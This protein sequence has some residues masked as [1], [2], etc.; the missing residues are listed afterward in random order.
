MKKRKW[1]IC[2]ICIFILVITIG[3]VAVGQNREKT[4]INITEI[5]RGENR[6]DAY[7]QYISR[8][9]AYEINENYE[10][11]NTEIDVTH[12]KEEVTSVDVHIS[13]EDIETAEAEIASYVSQCLD[14]PKEYVNIYFD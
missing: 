1:F 8:K 7:F 14:V 13:G 2:L 6:D 9:V 5:D 10:F 4:D 12:M 3:G 11:T